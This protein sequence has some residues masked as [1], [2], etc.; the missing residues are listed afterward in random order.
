MS[1][2][3]LRASITKGFTLGRAAFEKISAVEGVRFSKTMKSEFRRFDRE[4]LSPEERR[5][6]ITSKYTKNTDF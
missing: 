5:R 3:R 4:G 2:S 6:V 1:M